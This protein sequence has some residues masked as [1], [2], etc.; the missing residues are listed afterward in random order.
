M[1][2]LF[3]PGAIQTYTRVVTDQDIA[4]FDAGSVHPVY[5]TFSL[6][7]DAEWTGRLFVLAMK[8]ADEEGIGTGL[9]IEHKSPALL[10]QTVL[11]TATLWA[12]EGHEV[13]TD[14]EA[15]VHG[16]I[17]ARGRQWQKILKKVRIEQLFRSLES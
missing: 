12:V 4:A 6:A 9:T 10:G 16:R 17:I 3:E 15:T 13:I 11:F 8:E 1:K 2:R 5:A 7:R 14:Y